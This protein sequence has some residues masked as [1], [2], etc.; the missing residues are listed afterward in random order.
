MMGFNH[1]LTGAAGWVA[2]TASAPLLTTGIYPLGA[3]GVFTGAV[4]CAGA[5]LLPDADHHNGTIAHSIPLIGKVATSAIGTAAGGHRQGLHSILATIV[6]L[7]LSSGLSLIQFDTEWGSVPLGAGVAT[8]ALVAF[9]TRALKIARRSWVGPWILGFVL[10]AG[11]ILF[12][13]TEIAWLQIAITLGFVIHLLG[14]G[15]TIGGVPWLWPWKPKPPYWLN[16]IPVLSDIWQKNGYFALPIL[17]K[18]GSAREWVLG[19]LLTAYIL[20]VFVYEAFWAFGVNV[21]SL[22]A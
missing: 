21:L 9:A 12:A 2:V 22:F 5:A 6:I 4:V 20:C 14:D 7:A 16:S 8:M 10:A 15:L 19:A 1:A 11:I 17:G 18:A 3:V 13:P